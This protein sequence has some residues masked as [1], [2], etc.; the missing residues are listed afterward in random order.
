LVDAKL[1]IVKITIKNEKQ[2]ATEY[3]DV[4]IIG[5]GLSGIGAACHLLKKCPNKSYAILESREAMGGTWDLFKYPG[6]RSDS[7]MYTLGY[8]FK[9]WTDPQAIADAPA[10]L[11]YIKNTAEE[12]K[13]DQHI[14]YNHKATKIEWCSEKALWT[15]FLNVNGQ[16][17]IMTCSF[18][19]SCTGYYNYEHGFTPDFKGKENYQGQFIHPQLWPE[20][21]DYKD[22]QVVV[23]GSGAT[24]VTLIPELAKHAKMTTMLQRSPTYVTTLPKEDRFLVLLRK[25]L[26]DNWVYRFART[27]NIGITIAFYNYCRAFPNSARRFLTRMAKK[28]LPESFNMEHFKP[29]YAPWDERVCVVPDSDLFKVLSDGTAK[30]VTD[31]IDSFTETGI[32]LKSGSTLSADIVVSATGLNIQILGGIDV[33]VDGKPYDFSEKM[34]YRGVLFQDLPNLGMVFGYTNASWTL[35][36]DLVSEF[37]CRMINEMDASGTQ[38]VVPEDHESMNHIPFMEMSSGY[39][40]RALAKVPKQGEKLP[41]RLYQNYIKDMLTLRFGKLRDGVLIFKKVG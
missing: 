21:L 7:D 23:I 33:S 39:I 19:M 3:Q 17:K 26:P 34:I 28:E 25:V 30:I 5:A 14:Y 11:K 9:P 18:L 10:I 40:Q 22:K 2:M 27:R 41:W 15:V 8:S 38:F 16:Q 12:F 29:K 6:I 37:M 24:A 1:I 35:K 20:G 4:I 36:A 13:V 31:E 32:K